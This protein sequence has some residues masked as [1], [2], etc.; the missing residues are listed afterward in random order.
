MTVQDVQRQAFQS[1]ADDNMEKANL[2]ANLDAFGQTLIENNPLL[3]KR[4][5][6]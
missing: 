2:Q 3:E 6:Q 5:S 1:A 4:S